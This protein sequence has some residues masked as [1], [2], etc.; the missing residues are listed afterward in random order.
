MLTHDQNGSKTKQAIIY[1]P[2]DD[3]SST[4]VNEIQ[5]DPKDNKVRQEIN[6]YAPL[7]HVPDRP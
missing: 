1:E 7:T 6:E 3:L 2:K 5:H 4:V